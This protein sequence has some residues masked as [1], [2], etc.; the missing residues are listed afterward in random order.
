MYSPSAL[1]AFFQPRSIAVIGASG[2]LGKMASRPL[3]YLSK[4]GFQGGIYPVNPKYE[5]LGGYPCFKDIESLPPNVDLAM[6]SLPAEA[7]PEAVRRCAAKGIK[8]ATI[9]SG[10]FGELGTDAGRRVEEQLR[11]VVRETGIRVC[12]PNCQGGINLFDRVA[13][14]YSGALSSDALQAGPIALITQSGVFGGLVFAAAQEEGIGVGYWTSTGNEI[15]LTFSDFLD[16]I[17]KEDRIRV[18]GGYLESV[19]D[20]GPRFVQAL[21]RAR[22]AGKPV[23]IL[24]TGRTDAGRAAAASHTA[25]LAGSDEGYS[26]AFLKAG[27]VRVDSADAFRDLTAA[28]STGRVPQGRRVAILSISGGAATLM[29]DE[30]SQQGLEIATFSDA[31][32]ARLAEVV[33][34][35]GSVVNP[36]DLTGQLVADATLLEKAADKIIQSGEADILSIFIGMCDGNKNALVEV[37]G[38]LASRT[39]MP[40]AV[41]WVAAEDKSIYSRIR[42]H[43]VPVFNDASACIGTLAKMAEWALHRVHPPATTQAG[44][45]TTWHEF[46]QELAQCPPGVL[47]EATVKAMLRKAGLPVPAG[48]LVQNAAE[49]RH[50][51][52]SMDGDAVMKLQAVSVPHKSDVGGVRIGV[53]EDSAEENFAALKALF[54][55]DAE[56]VLVEERVRQATECFVGVQ[57]HPVFGP[58]VAVGLGGIFIE[59]FRDVAIRLAPVS[60]EE[61]H[62]MIES[63]KGFPILQGARGRGAADIAAL[64]K[65]VQQVSELASTN[66]DRI[67]E[68]DLN[69]VFVRPQG[70]GVVIGDAL[71]KRS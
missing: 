53:T 64:A 1:D 44:T 21:Q 9:L 35:F 39:E 33:P 60:V 13:A 52:A 37:I 8:V 46:K 57:R 51:V 70:Q 3:S 27:A 14:T 49:A 56:G 38:R 12:G 40:I 19:K 48:R 7:I 69:P 2:D 6:I 28:F 20:K 34:S 10:G 4:H 58:M 42:K 55:P 54:P 63:L 61:A 50:V 43:G 32:Q 65:L 24:K 59:V 15:D 66:G 16:Y 22:S 41:T 11:A 29:A 23:V 25:A 18:I 31:L 67:E 26:A 71:L 17:V 68:M 30:C 5:E 45:A 47:S 62:Q 36:V